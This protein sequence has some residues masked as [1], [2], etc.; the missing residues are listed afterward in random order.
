M[1]L[2]SRT[3]KHVYVLKYV[4]CPREKGPGYSSI[5]A[6]HVRSMYGMEN[7]LFLYY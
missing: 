5:V 2:P 6:I 3:I 7:K 1:A 4:D